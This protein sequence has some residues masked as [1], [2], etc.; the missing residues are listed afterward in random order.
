METMSRTREKDMP[1]TEMLM[2][3]PTQDSMPKVK[4]MGKAS[5]PTTVEPSMKV[6]GRMIR[7]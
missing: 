4:E 2:E 5:I 6:A 1:C 3:R 7:R